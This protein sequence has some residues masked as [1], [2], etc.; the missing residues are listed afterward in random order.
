E[1]GDGWCLVDC[2]IN[3]TEVMVLWD[4][5]FTGPLAGRPV[6]KLIVTH[7]HPDHLGLSGWLADRFGLTPHM[8]RAEWATGRMLVLESPD[9]MRG[10][11]L[12]FYAR[13]GFGPDLM[14]KAAKRGKSYAQR[15]QPVPGAFHCLRHG[16]SISIGGR[17]WRI[18]VGEGHS[19]EHAALYC[20]EAKVLISGDQIL[21]KISPNI[22]VWPQEP[23]AD[24]LSLYLGT[25][26]RFRGLAEDTLV[27]PSHNWPFRGLERRVDELAHH[28]DE[29][30]DETATACREAPKTALEVMKVLFKRE[31]DDHQLFFAIGEAVAHLSHLVTSGRVTMS[32][33][34]DGVRRYQSIK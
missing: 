29:R 12:A 7:F 34:A 24:P 15:I 10:P 27:L 4:R 28:H 19:P 6:T 16:G 11:A 1:D 18:I 8:T 33:D 5:L 14:E 26:D 20:E 31:L 13:S 17:E 22:S 25:L 23:D 2:G 9:S 3:R 32:D 21:P 30:L